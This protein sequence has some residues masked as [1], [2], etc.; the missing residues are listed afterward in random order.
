VGYST[1]VHGS[2][3]RNLSVQPSLSLTSKNAVSP[4]L[5]C[6]I[7]NKIGEQEGSEVAWK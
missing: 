4:Y 3:A 2:N 6:F 5:L 7:F 1:H